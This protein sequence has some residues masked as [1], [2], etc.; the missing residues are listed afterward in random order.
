M[1]GSRLAVVPPSTYGYTNTSAGFHFF[2]YGSSP[3][4]KT[5]DGASARCNRLTRRSHEYQLGLGIQRQHTQLGRSAT[6]RRQHR[7]RHS[8]KL[9]QLGCSTPRFEGRC[10][11]IS[12]PHL[13]STT[14]GSCRLPF[15]R[16][17]M[18]S[19]ATRLKV[20][21][22]C[23]KRVSS[24]E[25]MKEEMR[26]QEPLGQQEAKV[27]RLLRS[28]GEWKLHVFIIYRGQRTMSRLD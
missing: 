11:R 21:P 1:S 17:I 16:K 27:F 15:W 6:R 18:L 10:S 4:G 5:D 20:N 22:R 3:P 23:L 28:S 13:T 12:Q 8:L 19:S 14:I 2:S 9:H 25:D 26:H 24:R 7:E